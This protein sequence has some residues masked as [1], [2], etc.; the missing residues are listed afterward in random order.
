MPLD[1]ITKLIKRVFDEIAASDADG[2]RPGDIAQV[3]RERNQ[4]VPVWEI[5]GALARLEAEG[6]VS[7]DATHAIWRPAQSAKQASS[8]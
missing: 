6:L 3:L 4:P 7:L 1:R 2:V 8:Q 5:R